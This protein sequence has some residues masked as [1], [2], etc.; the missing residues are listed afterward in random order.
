MRA[1]VPHRPGTAF[2]PDSNLSLLAPWRHHSCHYS[3]LYTRGPDLM[4]PRDIRESAKKYVDDMLN[5]A[6]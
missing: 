6:G 3:L 4:H 2:K 5:Y 1:R